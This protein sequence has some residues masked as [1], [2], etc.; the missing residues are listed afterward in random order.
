MR[1]HGHCICALV[2]QVDTRTRVVII[3][4]PGER[5]H[6]FGTA[7]IL[8]LGLPN[9]AVHTV[10]GGFSRSLACRD[11]DVPDDAVLLYPHPDAIE[12]EDLAASTNTAPSTLVVLDGTWSHARRLYHENPWLQQL[13]HV[14]ITPAEPSRY[15]IRKEP[16]PECLST[17]EATVCALRT[18]ESAATQ[19]GLD[20][21]VAA[22]DG[23]ID[24]Q[25]G[26]MSSAPRQVRFRKPRQRQRRELSP[27]LEDP[28]FCVVYAESSL[29]GGDP[30]ATRELVQ[31]AFA[32]LTTGRSHE[33]L[34][35]PRTAPPPPGHLRHMGLTAD[36]LNGGLTL[37]E[38]RD[39]FRALAGPGPFGAWTQTMLD[40]T[41]ELMPDG[42]AMTVLKT[43]YCNYRH[44]G[45]GF[46][47]EVVEREQLEPEPTPCHGRA[48]NRLSN[49]LAVGRWLRERRRGQDADLNAETRNTESGP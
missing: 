34:L 21:L 10:H 22:F 45:S 24:H 7:K 36:E 19:R 17:L 43:S 48:A 40:W 14:R 31:V 28:G 15:R 25:I 39:R 44:R 47:E 30:G 46:L 41:A 8:G 42:A 37:D 35:R 5:D 20:K 38:A 16:R 1:P 2:P 26:H 18:L 27:L 3:Q 13:R 23:M 33:L 32:D 12:L 11:L 4:H 6:P 9:A 49:A 29:P